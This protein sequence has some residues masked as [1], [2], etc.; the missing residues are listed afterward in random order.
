MEIV[1]HEQWLQARLKGIGAS[2][3]SAIIGRNPYS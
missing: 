1:T 3:A 2:E